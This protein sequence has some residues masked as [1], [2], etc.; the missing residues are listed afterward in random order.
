MRKIRKLNIQVFEQHFYTKK[1]K[2][3]NGSILSRSTFDCSFFKKY[4]HLQ[5][6]RF[7]DDDLHRGPGLHYR[8]LWE[9]FG[10]TIRH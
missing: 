1:S 10:E 5:R 6:R 7:A 9:T 2:Y 8:K 3:K 4:V